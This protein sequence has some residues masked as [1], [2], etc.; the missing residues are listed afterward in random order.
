M[1]NMKKS[2]APRAGDQGPRTNDQ[3]V[4]TIALISPHLDDAVF[5]VGGLMAVLADAGHQ[6]HLITC[7]TRSVPQPTGF[8]LA[9]QLDKGLSAEADYM[10]LRREEDRRAC[11]LLGAQSHWLDL[12]E[13]PHRGY[14]SAAALFQDTLKADGIQP[15][16]TQRIR[17][18]CQT[19]RPD[20]ILSPVGIG[21]HVDHQQVKRAVRSVCADFPDAH[22][23]QWYDEPYLARHPEL[24][25]KKATTELALNWRVLVRHATL[26]DDHV[27]SLD[28]TSYVDRKIAACAAYTTQIG[29]QFG[30]TDQIRPAL[31]KSGQFTE[32]IV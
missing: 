14:E 15:E 1:R 17:Q 7:F 3:N 27:L 29:F 6:L 22:F 25:P 11:E 23:L 2:Q 30:G 9:C 12:P 31:A 8:A 19:I 18:A 32:L 26:P 16:L 28:I 13:A 21:N 10:Q 5:S 24:L 20:L 4:K